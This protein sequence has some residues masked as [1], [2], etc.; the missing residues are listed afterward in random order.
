MATT[1]DLDQEIEEVPV[2]EVIPVDTLMVLRQLAHQ[3]E[4]DLDNNREAVKASILEEVVK[5][6]MAPYYDYVCDR[7][8]WAKDEAL[9]SRMRAENAAEIAKLEAKKADAEESLGE[10]EVK[11][12][13][14]ELSKFYHKI[15]NKDECLKHLETLSTVHEKQLGFGAKLDVAFQRIRLGFA[16]GDKTLIKANITTAAE[17]LKNEGDWER[18]NRLK[19]YEG[20]YSV[21]VRDFQRASQLFLESVATFSSYEL[22]EY[23]QFIVY[24][25]IAAIPT[26]SRPDLRTKVVENSEVLSVMPEPALKEVS[27]LLDSIYNCNYRAFFVA[28]DS[29][30]EYMRRNAWFAPHVNYYFREVRVLAFNQFLASYRSV[31]LKN[32]A[33]SFSISPEILDKQLS[34]FIASNRLVCKIDKVTGQVTTA[35]YDAKNANYQTLIKE[36]DYLLNKVQK[37]AR[38]VGA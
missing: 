19:V 27:S 29:V 1:M 34:H 37:L 33:E 12:V 25:V 20:L 26:L 5:N 3:Y 6:G 9:L 10:T 14:L 4:A 17:I 36:G 31:T 18:R 24:T 21:L 11:D 13:Q 28:L 23:T 30:C 2:E 35:R 38:I 8:S 15:G 22:M 16:F 7:Y 32:M